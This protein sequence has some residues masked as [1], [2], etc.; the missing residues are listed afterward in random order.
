M[1]G[2]R[3]EPRVK[4]GGDEK[5]RWRG[6]DG[7]LPPPFRWFSCFVLKCSAGAEATTVAAF[8]KFSSL[9]FKRGE[10]VKP[11]KVGHDE[12]LKGY[13]AQLYRLY[14]NF[15][16]LLAKRPALSSLTTRNVCPNAATIGRLLKNELDFLS[17]LS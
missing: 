12:S 4:T 14:V 17:P 6:T 1:D 9:N 15:A 8:L 16:I 3:R 5:E 7:S 10:A 11:D 13:S 2:Q